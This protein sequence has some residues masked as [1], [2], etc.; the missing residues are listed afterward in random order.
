MSQNQKEP[1]NLVWTRTNLLKLASSVRARGYNMAMRWN[2]AIL[3]A[4]K[5]LGTRLEKEHWET[6]LPKS[7]IIFCGKTR[8]LEL[9]FLQRR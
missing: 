5:A 3:N 8:Q 1:Q 9:R 4:E 2:A 6:V 7:P